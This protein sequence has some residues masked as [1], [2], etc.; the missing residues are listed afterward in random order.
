MEL[1][2]FSATNAHKA[3]KKRLHDCVSGACSTLDPDTIALDN[4][5]DLGKW[6]YRIRESRPALSTDTQRL[7]TR[8]FEEHAAFHRVA[9][10]VARQALANQRQEA[11]QQ[12][13]GG[14]EYARISNQVI[15]TLGDLYL[16]RR[17]FGMD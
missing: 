13:Q 7:F 10:D 12:L 2:F 14:G 15:G 8:L 16:K 6:L 4:R 9:A 5:C 1:N 3:W 17:E 11:L